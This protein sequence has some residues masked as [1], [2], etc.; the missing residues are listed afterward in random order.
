MIYRHKKI[1]K[2]YTDRGAKIA[3]GDYLHDVKEQFI[4]DLA[5]EITK[6]KNRDPE[7]FRKACLLNAIKNK[8]IINGIDITNVLFDGMCQN[9]FDSDK[10]TEIPPYLDNLFDIYKDGLLNDVETYFDLIINL[11]ESD[12]LRKDVAFIIENRVKYTVLSD[13]VT[14]EITKDD[15]FDDLVKKLIKYP[16]VEI[17]PV[18]DSSINIIKHLE[19]ECITKQVYYNY[20]NNVDIEFSKIFFFNICI[21]LGLEISFAETFLLQHGLSIK[22]SKMNLDSVYRLIFEFGMDRELSEIY[23]ELIFFRKKIISR[24]IDIKRNYFG[25]LNTYRDRDTD[26]IFKSNVQYSL[27]KI[28]SAIEKLNSSYSKKYNSFLKH[29]KNYNEN[30]TNTNLALL[31]KAEKSL[32]TIK[33]NLSISGIDVFG[34]TVEDTEWEKEFSIERLTEL[35]MEIINSAL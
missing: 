9:L 14:V 15:T 16:A 13:S 27:R 35:K 19:R 18:E 32:V 4:K 1:L 6:L 5:L 17:T 7:L 28:D 24:N 23:L 30:P 26:A 8:V 3:Y 20:K 25:L 29:E 10:K 2:E 34:K 33:E 12:D 22:E 31:I 21:Y 11:E